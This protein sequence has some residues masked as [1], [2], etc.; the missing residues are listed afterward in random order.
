MDRNWEGNGWTTYQKLVL[1]QLQAHTENLNK[2]EEKITDLRIEL[3]TLKVQAGIWG[4]AAGM[5][6]VIISI[7]MTLISRGK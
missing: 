6:P 5:I 7:G 3:T 2:L 4:L 1:T